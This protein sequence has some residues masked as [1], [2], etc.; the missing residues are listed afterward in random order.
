M[1]KATSPPD[2]PLSSMDESDAFN[3]DGHDTPDPMPP[4]K[5]QKLQLDVSTASSAVA[6]PDPNDPALEGLSPVSSD[7][8]GDIPSSPAHHPHHPHHL[9]HGDTDDDLHE[10]VSVCA[11]GDCDAGDLG[12]M[13][14]LVEHIHSDHIEGKQKNN[15]ICEWKGCGRNR[16]LH[17]SG[18]ALKA[19]MRS[20]TREKPFYCYLPECDRSFTRSDAL[21]KHMRTVHE[22]EA[23]RPSDPIPKAMQAQTAAGTSTKSGKPLT[24]VIKTPRSHAAGARDSVLDRDGASPGSENSFQFTELTSE[25]GFS[26]KELA[27]PLPKLHNLLRCTLKWTEEE[28]QELQ[29]EIEAAETAYKNAWLEKEVLLH[30]VI[31]NEINWH[32]RR[33]AVLSG[34]ADVQ[35]K[36]V[37][38]NGT[39]AA[40]ATAAADDADS[41][42]G[43]TEEEMETTMQD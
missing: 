11:W 8:S 36:P 15:Y 43:L 10:Q 5:R 40:A 34:V 6:G 42:G 38:V 35:A 26:P 33:Q 16:Q 30:Q 41:V 19:H 17:A 22:T 14:R 7:T 32:E 18:Y 1:A 20:H 3:E 31:Q 13:D 21:A 37:A 9:R 25:Q 2:S 29:R 4:A 27:M 39:P 28:Q 12:N 24:I 23:L